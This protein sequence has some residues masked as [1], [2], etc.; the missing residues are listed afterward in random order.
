MQK[1]AAIYA[2]MSEGFATGQQQAINTTFDLGRALDGR[3]AWN[4]ERAIK[5]MDRRQARKL[6]GEI[7]AMRRT[8]AYNEVREFLYAR[9]PI[10][11]VQA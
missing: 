2:V 4:I 10:Q 9:F 3:V 5:A 11:E 8:G 1:R 7:V 6:Y